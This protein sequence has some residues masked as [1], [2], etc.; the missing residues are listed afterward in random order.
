[1]YNCVGSTVLG[2]SVGVF[3]GV[4]IGGGT[5]WDE[6]INVGMEP[7]EQPVD[8]LGNS[9]DV[10]GMLELELIFNKRWGSRV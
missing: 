10:K 1:M 6:G 7:G 5:G 2:S 3:L 8:S 4:I 9:N